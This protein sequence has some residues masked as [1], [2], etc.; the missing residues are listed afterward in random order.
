MCCYY[1]LEN[2]TVDICIDA[3]IINNFIVISIM[4]LTDREISL[5]W[6]NRKSDNEK[7]EL[8]KLAKIKIQNRDF[9]TL[10]GS[11]IEYIW[12]NQPYNT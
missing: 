9:K 11:E 8:A 12:R 5:R 7:T 4:E 3:F 6:W 2:C 1:P 10:T